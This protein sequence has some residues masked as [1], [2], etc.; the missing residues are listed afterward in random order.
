MQPIY[1][2]LTAL[3]NLLNT[4]RNNCI[5]PV[6]QGQIQAVLN[7]LLQKELQLVNA[8]L[9]AT[10]PAYTAASNSLGQASTAAQNAINDINQTAATINSVVK[11]AKVVD[12]ALNAVVRLLK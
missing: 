4:L 1:N 2:Q 11:A 9:D 12:S 7:P 8:Q 3:I 10:T 5:D 6:V